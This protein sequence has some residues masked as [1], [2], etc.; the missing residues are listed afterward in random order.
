MSIL[1]DETIT[2]V[3]WKAS[4]RVELLLGDQSILVSIIY[5]KTPIIFY[6]E[7]FSTVN[8]KYTVDIEVENKVS[9]VM[10]T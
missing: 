1:V 10:D 8:T 3:F 7:K 6:Y 2:I 5:K 9:L 4:R